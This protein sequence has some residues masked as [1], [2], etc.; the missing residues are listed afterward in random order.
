MV[1]RNTLKAYE[2]ESM[3]DYYNYIVNSYNNGQHMQVENLINGLA[4]QQKKD[5]FMDLE[6]NDTIS[7]VIL[8]GIRVKL[9]E[10]L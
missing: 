5:F 10:L 9:V 7:D 4:K 6:F 1:T 3:E 2:F 8:R